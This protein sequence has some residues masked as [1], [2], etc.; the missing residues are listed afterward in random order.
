MFWALFVVGHDWW[1]DLALS[2]V[3][4]LFC[5]RDWLPDPPSMEVI[6]LLCTQLWSLLVFLTDSRS[7]H[8]QWSQQLQQQQ[9]AK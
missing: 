6:K 8:A 7:P 4:R 2:A 9:A 3:K 1:A 5:V